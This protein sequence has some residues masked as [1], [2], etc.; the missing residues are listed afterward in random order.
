VSSNQLSPNSGHTNAQ[1][2]TQL[3][4]WVSARALY[5]VREHPEGNA[6]QITLASWR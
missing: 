1:I 3:F 6:A 4:L 2:G 5:G